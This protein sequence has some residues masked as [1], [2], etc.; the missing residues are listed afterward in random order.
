MKTRRPAA[1][2]AAA[3]LWTGLLALG[4]CE[5]PEDRPE[6]EE[7]EL[8][9]DTVR[10]GVLGDT[11][12]IARGVAEVRLTGERRWL[13]DRAVL[14]SAGLAEGFVV[15]RGPGIA[16]VHF[17]LPDGRQRDLVVDVRPDGPAVVELS[18]P[19]PAR[20][21]D[22]AVL[23]GYRMAELDTS[24]VRANG[25]GPVPLGADS[26]N[27]R[28]RV[29]PADADEEACRGA[30]RVRIDVIDARA[31]D[32]LSFRVRRDGELSLE[33]GEA[34]TL[35]PGADCLRLAPVDSARYALTY[36]DVDAIREARDG[37]EGYPVQFE[38][39][40][41]LSSVRVEGRVAPPWADTEPSAVPLFGAGPAPGP[42]VRP[43]RPLAGV[44]RLP[45]REGGPDRTGAPG[46]EGGPN[47]DCEERDRRA[48]CTGFSAGARPWVRGETF[49]A[50]VPGGR[51]GRARVLDVVGGYLT[52]AL[53]EPDSAALSEGR[54]AQLREV[55]RAAV[56]RTVPLLEAAFGPR[57]VTGR[58]TGQ[59]LLLLSRFGSDSVTAEREVGLTYFR[60]SGGSPTSWITLNLGARWTDV[61]LLELLSHELAHAF[62]H[63]YLHAHPGQGGEERWGNPTFWAEEG[64]AE[65]FA[66]EILRRAAGIDPDANFEGWHDG[67]ASGVVQRYSGEARYAVGT[68]TAGYDHAASFLRDL[69]T[70][71]VQ[72][73]GESWEEASAAVARGALEGWFGYDEFGA[74]RRGLTS[75]MRAAVDSAW[76][77]AA[78][79][80]RWATSQALDD[81]TDSPAYQNRAFAEVSGR[82]PCSCGWRPHATLKAGYAHD[83]RVTR[84]YGSTGFFFLDDRGLG[85]SYL[86]EDDDTEHPVRWT[87]A[88]YR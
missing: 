42:D 49:R 74:R 24:R 48:P 22:T 36:L 46:Q 85:G 11:A 2:A 86:L 7:L 79:V 50:D 6:P 5:L 63:R 82:H 80:L 66:H 58:G 87:V 45:A 43:G 20:G 35:D 38:P 52:V 68:L 15:A 29:P 65:F 67:S 78:A 19:R 34:R 81:R 3:L 71:R 47:P 37:P 14:D 56:D 61:S 30:G 55:G 16:G 57:P 69:A 88:R 31:P 26:A 12:G 51:S 8:P 64:V 62:S 75:R 72:R 4:A 44:R 27:F 54:R 40:P 10:I 17:A 32:R 21:G 9:G 73:T 39:H 59:L 83:Y 25:W 33:V 53:F 13:D 18:V 1:R 41:D 76:A 60:P 70:R 23:R 77:P 84:R 28:F